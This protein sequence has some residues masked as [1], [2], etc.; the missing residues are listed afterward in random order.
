MYFSLRSV[1]TYV[2]RTVFLTFLATNTSSDQFGT[3]LFAKMFLYFDIPTI[4]PILN[5]GFSSVTSLRK[6]INVRD[7]ASTEFVLIVL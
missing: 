7:F 1:I 5:L 3:Q 2:Q 6:S 4:S